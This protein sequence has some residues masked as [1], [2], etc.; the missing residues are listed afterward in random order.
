M[1]IRLLIIF[2]LLTLLPTE[3]G[4]VVLRNG[5]T[6]EGEVLLHN[7]EV[8]I[9]RDR[10]GARYQY[11]AEEVVSVG[12]SPA[13]DSVPAT[14]AAT[15]NQ[16]AATT[17]RVVLRLNLS[18]GFAAVGNNLY[19]GHIGGELALGSRTIKGKRMM[20][21]GS[22]GVIA[23]LYGD[24]TSYIYIPLQAA[25]SCPLTPNRHAP[26][27]GLEM[28]YAFSASHTKGGV[29]AG[30]HVAWR[31][32]IS[33]RSALLLGLKFRV[34]QDRLPLNFNLDDLNYTARLGRCV[35]ETGLNLVLEF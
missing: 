21:G 25:I 7:E 22:I 6:V 2:L 26:E 11:P 23:D 18:G 19:G 27:V 28:G 24:N 30:A 35:T 34:R 32:Q 20:I 9:L 29:T 1:R 8:I 12:E 16:P 15:K 31:Y 14:A 5:K 33:Q 4:V 3:A 17:S 13:A 10:S